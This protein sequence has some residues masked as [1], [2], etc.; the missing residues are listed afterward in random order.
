MIIVKVMGGLGNQ[1]YAYALYR[2]LEY[3][4]KD[5]K[6]DIS[7]FEWE[8][9]NSKTVRGYQLEKLACTPIRYATAKEVS[10][11]GSSNL[12][13]ILRRLRRLGFRKS[14][15][16]YEKDVPQGREIDFFQKLDSGYLEGYWTTF[17]F[18]DEIEQMLKQDFDFT[19]EDNGVVKEKGD[20]IEKENSVSVHIRRGDYVGNDVYYSLAPSYYENAIN[21]MR[22]SL[23]NPKFY[24]FSDDIDY[25]RKTILADDVEF[26]GGKNWSSHYDMYLMSKCKHHIVANS[27]FGMWAAWLGE[28]KDT[29][30]VR[31]RHYYTNSSICKL[32]LW[33]DKWVTIDE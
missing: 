7:Y 32:R 22:R 24:V 23:N 3:I 5:V 15:H 21:Y 29:I 10:K 31:P 28:K 30:V 1:L 16:I 2:Y 33:P 17:D 9:K 18:A 4:G 14:T 13:I 20:A 11:L 8:K 26:V 25:C 12:N 6:L 19:I 27:T